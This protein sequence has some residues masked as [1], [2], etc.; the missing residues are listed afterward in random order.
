M[1]PHAAHESAAILARLGGLSARIPVANLPG[2]FP[3]A[4]SAVYKYTYNVDIS[5][6]LCD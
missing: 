1:K 4:Y 2:V 3:E 6:V 5:S